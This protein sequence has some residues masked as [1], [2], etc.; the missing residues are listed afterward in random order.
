MSISITYEKS[1]WWSNREIGY[2]Q[3]DNISITVNVICK[4]TVKA[5]LPLVEFF[6]E[7]G[8]SYI[9]NITEKITLKR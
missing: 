5:N 4:L 1:R 7:K 8:C 9:Y 6:E 2:I 3:C